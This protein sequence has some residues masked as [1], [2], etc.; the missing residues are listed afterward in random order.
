MTIKVRNSSYI[1][2]VG[3]IAALYAMLTYI[4][5]AGVSYGPL[6]FRLSEGLVLLPYAEPAAI[7]GVTIGCFISNLASPFGIVDIVFGSLATL[8]AAYFTNKLSKTGN[9]YLAALPP[10]FTNGLGVSIY[11][12]YLGHTPYWITAGYITLSEM[13]AVYG[14]AVPILTMYTK[15][16]KPRLI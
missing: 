3:L 12:S 7:L 9:V 1:T 10:I 13:I 6:Q 8:V 5:P 2:K 16:V 15:Y 14:I 4:L 11:V